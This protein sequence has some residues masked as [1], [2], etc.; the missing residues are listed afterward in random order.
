MSEVIP[1]S[2]DKRQSGYWNEHYNTPE[3][4][5]KVDS[6]QDV[7]TY[8]IEAGERTPDYDLEVISAAEYTGLEDD[9]LIVDIGCSFPRFLELCKYTGHKRL[10]GIEPNTA[11]FN[12]APYWEPKGPQKEYVE[13][14]EA[15]DELKLADFFQR[16]EEEPNK[17]DY[18]G[19]ELFK[20]DA[21]FI[22]VPSQS[23][24]LATA[25]FSWYH[26]APEKQLEALDEVKRILK[27]GGIFALVT[28]GNE[29]KEG[30]HKDQ[31]RIAQVASYILKQDV[32][33]PPPLHLGFTTEKAFQSLPLKFKYLY[34]K[35]FEKPDIVV[36]DEA[37]KSIILRAHRTQF[38]Q[39]RNPQGEPVSEAL[40]EAALQTVVS[41]Q[42]DDQIVLG[43]AYR[44]KMRR[45]IFFAS[46]RQLNLPKEFLPISGE[47]Y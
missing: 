33:P 22:P 7:Y 47:I 37:K 43:K 9:E 41:G 39:F 42:I 16:F 26:I 45:A 29:N 17:G 28:S 38:D 2:E 36:D 14:L 19:I 5:K 1:R 25:M 40:L 11:Q 21:N 31:D 10:I 20:A 23:A 46:D 6:R 34:V 15:G 30:M 27:T 12:G 35:F 13:L 24:S 3:G 8:C 4:K 18:E 32:Q 44:D